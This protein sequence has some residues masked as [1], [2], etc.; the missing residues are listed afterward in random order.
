[1]YFKEKEEWENLI[2]G[3]G[4]RNHRRT[5]EYCNQLELSYGYA[6]KARHKSVDAHRYGPEEL[7]R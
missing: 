1:M 3:P 5:T 2:R 4:I 7:V 6:R